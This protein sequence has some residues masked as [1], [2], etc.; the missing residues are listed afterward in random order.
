[1]E[2]VA[3]AKAQ[4][5]LFFSVIQYANGINQ[6]FGLS[7]GKNVIPITVQA[8]NGSSKTYSITV[9]RAGDSSS[10]P[11][12]SSTPSTPTGGTNVDQTGTTANSG[13]MTVNGG[14]LSLGGSKS[15]CQP[16]RRIAASSFP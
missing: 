2:D 16:E 14:S 7:V 10:V 12:T 11:P 1:M 13:T 15:M 6:S 3:Q 4:E 9:V 5:Q 8:R